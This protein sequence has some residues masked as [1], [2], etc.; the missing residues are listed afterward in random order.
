ALSNFAIAAFSAIH[1]T[2]S[3]E[4]ARALARTVQSDPTITRLSEVDVLTPREREVAALLAL[5]LS[6]RGI[7]EALVI[8]ETT[9]EVHV[10]HILTEDWRLL[11]QVE[12]RTPTPSQQRRAR[13]CF[14][15][16][17]RSRSGCPGL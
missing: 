7:A 15:A 6:N 5:G 4:R 17:E 9:A 12:W 3:L 1:M 10:K 16:S 14:P 8:T 2:P 11:Q 13:Q